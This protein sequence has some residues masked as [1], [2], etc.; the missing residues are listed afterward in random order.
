M[1]KVSQEGEMNSEELFHLLGN[2]LKQT[3]ASS[4]FKKPE[5]SFSSQNSISSRSFISGGFKFKTL[6]YELRKT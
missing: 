4:D 2:S 5:N 1:E 6:R 3:E